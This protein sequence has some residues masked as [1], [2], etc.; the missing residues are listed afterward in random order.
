MKYLI[1]GSGRSGGNLLRDI[2]RNTGTG[3][4]YRH[5]FE[6]GYD[7]TIVLNRRNIFDAIMSNVIVNNSNQTTS[8][9][10]DIIPFVASELVFKIKLSQ[11]L[12]FYKN[13]ESLLDPNNTLY[14]YFEDFV[15]NYDH[16]YS[17]LGLPVPKLIDVQTKAPYNYKDKV[18]NWKEMLIIYNNFLPTEIAKYT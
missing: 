7:K 17:S 6:E 16:V 14:W 2:I 3:A 13:L 4:T 1:V 5:A 18:L 11:H 8:Y 15:D 9:R 10:D 12:M